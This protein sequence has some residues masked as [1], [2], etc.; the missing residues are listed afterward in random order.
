MKI[1]KNA[2]FTVAVVALIIGLL[3]I[4]AGF[5]V[6]PLGVI[7]NTVLIA[8]GETLTFVGS[9]IG[10]DCNYRHKMK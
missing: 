1:S 4:I 7:D 2:Q 3:M 10:I 6:P 8:Y 9:V 5:I